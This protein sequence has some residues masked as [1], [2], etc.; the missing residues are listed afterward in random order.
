M[1]TLQEAITYTKTDLLHY[2]AMV[3]Q[4]ALN[5]LRLVDIKLTESTRQSVTKKPKGYS[6]VKRKH[7]KLGFVYYVRYWHEGRMLPSKW[8]ARTNNYEAAREFAERYRDILIGEYESRTN[9]EMFNVLN[10]FY[11]KDSRIYQSESLR[12]GEVKE[13]TRERYQSVIKNNFKPFLMNRKIQSFEDITVLLLY[14]F[15]DYLLGKG[16]KAKSVNNDMTA[17]GKIFTYLGR[18]GKIKTNPYLSLERLPEKL[19]ESRKRGCYE[20]EEIKG[21]FETSC[22]GEK[23]LHNVLNLLIYTTDMRNSEIGRIRKKDIVTIGGVRF[24][25]VKES[26]T[27]N[28]IRLVPLHDKVYS[29]L[30]KRAEGLEEEEAIFKSPSWNVFKGATLSLGKKL[31]YSED[32]LRENYITFYSGR[33][34]WKTVMSAGGLGEDAEEIFMG[35]RVTNDVAKRYNHRDKQGKELIVKKAKDVFRILDKYLFA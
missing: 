33:H 35:H 5:A 26:K 10:E 11:A 2:R 1:L 29:K 22:K 23:D 18:K 27:E 9:G 25:D 21:V 8:S 19:S 6:L 28:G 17:V 13:A 34:F 14:D 30:M 32:Y 15:Q 12:N 24:I 31:G 20:V 4:T 7:N 16:K 3:P